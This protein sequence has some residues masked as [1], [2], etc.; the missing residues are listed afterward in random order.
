MVTFLKTNPFNTIPL[1]TPDRKALREA[2]AAQQQ[3]Q[4]VKQEQLLHNLVSLISTLAKCCFAWSNLIYVLQ[5]AVKQ[6]W[7]LHSL[8]SLPLCR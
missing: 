5:Q 8:V 4:A 3:Q 2:L 6:E 1:V 7:L